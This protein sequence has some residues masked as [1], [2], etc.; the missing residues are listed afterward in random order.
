V[1][2]DT[3]IQQLEKLCSVVFGFTFLIIFMLISAGLY[4]IGIIVF[5]SILE[6]VSSEY[7][8]SWVLPILPF[9]IVYLFGG[10]IYF[11]DFISLGWIKQNVG[12]TK[13][14]YPL[15]RFFGIITLAFV[16]RPMYYNMVDNKFG[17]K[18]VLFIIPYVLLI[19]LIVGLS[20]K[21][22]AYLPDNRQLQ[23]MTNTYYDDTADLKIPSYSAS[24]NSK[25]VKNGFAELYLPYVARSDDPVIGALCPDLKA[26]KTGIFI[27]GGR[28]PIRARMNAEETMKCHAQRFK[29]Y[30]NDSLFDNISYRFHEHPTRENIGLFTILDVEYLPRGEHAI[31]IHVKFLEKNNGKDTLVMRETNIIPFWKE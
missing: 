5:A 30:V 17:R 14:Y 16:Y 28:D 24:I 31:K 11:L 9:F 1:N 26:A 25:F 22:Q 29:I 19:T 7:G 21:T 8:G 6:G 2:F 10:I 13:F 27:F 18:V 23:S 3:Y 12:F 15:Y 4:V 20:F